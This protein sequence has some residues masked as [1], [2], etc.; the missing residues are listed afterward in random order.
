MREGFIAPPSELPSRFT[1]SAIQA[2][3][4]IQRVST[5]GDSKLISNVGPFAGFHLP[6][7]HSS[8]EFSL[9]DLN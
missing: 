8:L 7:L 9:V 2:G 5:G 4:A 1:F 6:R 3:F